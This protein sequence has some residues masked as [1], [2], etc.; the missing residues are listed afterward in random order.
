MVIEQAPMGDYRGLIVEVLEFRG[1]YGP[2]TTH[3]KDK[4]PG[5]PRWWVRS[6][7]PIRCSSGMLA[8][9]FI[10]ADIFLRPIRQQPEDAVDETLIP[11]Y[12][13]FEVTA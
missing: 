12:V 3:F 9:E 4:L 8:S 5:T 6:S 1:H 10:C 7:R 11:G 13:K 2:F